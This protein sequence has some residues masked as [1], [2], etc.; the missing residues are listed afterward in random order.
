MRSIGRR[1]EGIEKQLNAGRE[2]KVIHLIMGLA[3]QD[4][5]APDI[6]EPYE[7]WI[8]YK[9]VL[10]KA[11]KRGEETGLEVLLFVV[12]PFREYEVRNNLPEGILSKHELKGKIPFDQLLEKATKSNEKQQ[13]GEK[14]EAAR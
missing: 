10:E 9:A 12:D 3:S 8:T 13:K 14:T 1:L 11:V 4:C 7:D 5:T 2:K 6:P